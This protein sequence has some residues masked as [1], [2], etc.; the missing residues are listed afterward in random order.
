DLR[1]IFLE[2]ARDMQVYERQLFQENAIKTRTELEAKGM[3]FVEVDRAAFVEKHGDAIYRTL[4]PEM[5]EIYRF[6]KDTL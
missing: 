1:T 6:L 3:I 4:S 5:Q 2:C